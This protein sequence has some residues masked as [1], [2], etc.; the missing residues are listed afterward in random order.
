MKTSP[1][2][3]EGEA[4]YAS[5]PALSIVVIGRNE[6][7]QLARCLESIR[8]IHGFE[9]IQLIYADSAST[10]GSPELAAKYDSEVV[11]VHPERPTAAI[12]RNAGWRRATAEIVL[13]L[14]G[15]T[16]LHPDFPRAAFDAMSADCQICAVWGHRREMH[17]DQ[18][19]Y[20]RVLDLDW[21]YAPGFMEACGGDVLMRRSALIKA[22]GFDERL[23]AGEE[24]ELCRRLRAQGHLILHIDHPMTRHDL[25]ITRWSQYWKR[26]RRAGYAYA[27]ISDR[28]RHSEDPLWLADARRGFVNGCFWGFSLIAALAASVRYS[29][30]PITIW[31]CLFLAASLRSAWR[32]RWKSDNAVTLIFYG[33]HSHLQHLPISVGQLQ[34]FLDKRRGKQ[35]DLIEYKQNESGRELISADLQ[36]KEVRA[37]LARTDKRI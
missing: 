29:Y 11:V 7:Q 24:P 30:V 3:L 18:S 28:F 4:A 34:Y 27:E 1:D 6:G 10:D 20:N 31:L 23:I 13:F 8:A 36:D 19:I 2:R 21:I 37:G 5:C 26:A 22:G 15:D 32:A 12:G 25:H 14:D 16:V 9:K 17:P 35:R 33:A